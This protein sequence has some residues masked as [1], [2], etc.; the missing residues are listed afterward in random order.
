MITDVLEAD[1]NGN[2]P[3]AKAKEQA[4]ADC[5]STDG[6][7]TVRKSAEDAIEA[8]VNGD[9]PTDVLED[10]LFVNLP[11]G[12]AAE[13]DSAQGISLLSYLSDRPELVSQHKNGQLDMEL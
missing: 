12:G 7:T 3:D 5:Q 9:A 2:L 8:A 4:G 13:K 6:K 10:D 1:V 11:D